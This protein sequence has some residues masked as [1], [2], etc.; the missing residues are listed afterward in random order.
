M[1]LAVDLCEQL[2]WIFLKQLEFVW[3]S[4]LSHIRVDFIGLI[5]AYFVSKAN[6]AL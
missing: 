2:H 3:L 6:Q 4:I 1:I 5:C